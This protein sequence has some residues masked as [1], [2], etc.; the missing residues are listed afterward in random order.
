MFCQMFFYLD[1]ANIIIAI[2]S[3]KISNPIKPS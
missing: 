1:L 2:N 3:S